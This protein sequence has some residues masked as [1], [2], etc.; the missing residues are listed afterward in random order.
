MNM[1]RI[2][3]FNR[4][5]FSTDGNGITTLIALAGCPLK[6]KYCINKKY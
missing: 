1:F 6:C 5:R 2:I 3:I 4:H